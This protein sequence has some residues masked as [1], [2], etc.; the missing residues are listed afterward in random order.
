MNCVCDRGFVWS[1]A[2]VL[3]R[4][5]WV[6]DKLVARFVILNCFGP[7]SSGDICGVL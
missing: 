7:F 4:E 6:L 1:N 5:A 3:I 2:E